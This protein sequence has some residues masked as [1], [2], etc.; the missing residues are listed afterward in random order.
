MPSY[1]RTWNKPWQMWYKTRPP[2]ITA[3]N[4]DQF[5]HYDNF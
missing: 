2:S 5:A 1:M 4:H 3:F